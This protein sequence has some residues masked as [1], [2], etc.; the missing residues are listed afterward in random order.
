VP[1]VRRARV[2]V[3]HG[4]CLRESGR[5]GAFLRFPLGQDDTAT[6][7]QKLLTTGRTD[8]FTRFISKKGRPFKAYLAKTAEGKIGFEFEARKPKVEKSAIAAT[9]AP[10][11]PTRKEPAATPAAAVP[12]RKK[13]KSPAKTKAAGAAAVAKPA[14]KTKRK[15]AK[16][17]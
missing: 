15:A 1:E 10:T 3:R 6:A 12:A 2:R 16:A 8:L 17:A 4:V 14:A 13:T 9:P 5:R 11:R 7:D